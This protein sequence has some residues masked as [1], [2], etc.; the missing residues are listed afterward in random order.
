M[1]KC[2]H[3]IFVVL[4]FLENCVH[5][6]VISYVRHFWWFSYYPKVIL[7]VWSIAKL[8]W[9]QAA[10]MRH[11]PTC[12]GLSWQAWQTGH[13][14]L[15][16]CEVNVWYDG[17]S[18]KGNVPC[19]NKTTH[20]PS[21]IRSP[22]TEVSWDAI[23]HSADALL[24][25]WTTCQWCLKQDLYKKNVGCDNEKHDIDTT[26]PGLLIEKRTSN[27]GV[28]LKVQVYWLYW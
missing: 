8:T 2:W 27:S 23:A 16:F 18:M 9:V 3:A 22:F 13:Q 11:S 19:T 6:F 10:R 14:H 4:C 24:V 15:R 21:K 25:P 5:M 7:V 12:A 26:L 1:L 28:S 20:I 17:W